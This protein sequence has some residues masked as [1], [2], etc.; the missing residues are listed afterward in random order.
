[1]PKILF[2]TVPN[3]KSKR[4]FIKKRIRS[5]ADSRRWILR[6]RVEIWD[7]VRGAGGV[8][9]LL[10]MD[11]VSAEAAAEN[12]VGEDANRTRF[13]VWVSDSSFGCFVLVG[14]AGGTTA[15]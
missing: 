6:L 13:R 12:S 3:T 7:L 14:W 5:L 10:G 11:G 2:P 4:I 15:S 9:G 8:V 1:M